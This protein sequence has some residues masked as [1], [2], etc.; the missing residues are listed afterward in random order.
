MNNIQKRFALF[1]FGCI[2][3]RLLLA[4][5][6]KHANNIILKWMSYVAIIISITFFYLF[7]SGS[8]KVGQ[9]TFGQPIWWNNLRPIHGTLYLLFAMDAYQGNPKAYMYLFIDVIFGF[10]SFLV[11][12][13]SNGDFSRLLG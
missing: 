13:F 4:F 12:H 9:E 3:V 8:R 11:F 10:I 1:L 2:P 5:I 6:A 7:F